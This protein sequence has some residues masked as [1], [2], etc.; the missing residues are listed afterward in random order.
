MSVESFVKF[1]M[2][3]SGSFGAVFNQFVV[4]FFHWAVQKGLECFTSP[5]CPSFPTSPG[6]VAVQRGC[7]RKKKIKSKLSS[8]S[9]GDK[10]LNSKNEKGLK[11]PQAATA[12]CPE[13]LSV[14]ECQEGEA[15]SHC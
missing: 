4:F 3:V 14:C 12:D 2:L 7:G 10:F 9:Q 1:L 13:Q 8:W 6:F 15:N 11:K 5:C